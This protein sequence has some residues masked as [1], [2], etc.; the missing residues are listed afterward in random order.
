MYIRKG[1]N[2]EVNIPG[3]TRAALTASVGIDGEKA[4]DNMGFEMFH[5]LLRQ[6]ETNLCDTLS[7][8][9]H[10]DEYAKFLQKKDVMKGALDLYL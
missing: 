5:D 2:M 3:K 6:I 1:S 4:T 10:T 9:V 7:R 8:L